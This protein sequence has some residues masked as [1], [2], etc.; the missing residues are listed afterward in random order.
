M[1]KNKPLKY[2]ILLSTAAI[3]LAACTPQ[4]N[5]FSPVPPP[6]EVPPLPQ[7]NTLEV[8]PEEPAEPEYDAFLPISA[9]PPVPD[10]ELEIEKSL[11]VEEAPEDTSEKTLEEEVAATLAEET[12]KPEESFKP[13]PLPTNKLVD[14]PAIARGPAPQKAATPTGQAPASPPKMPAKGPQGGEVID[15]STYNKEEED[16]APTVAAWE[17]KPIEEGMVEEERK[18]PIETAIS[19]PFNVVPPE[20]RVPLKP[21]KV[22]DFTQLRARESMQEGGIVVAEAKTVPN[23]KDTPKIGTKADCSGIGLGIAVATS[24]GEKKYLLDQDGKPCETAEVMFNGTNPLQARSPSQ[25]VDIKFINQFETPTKNQ[26]PIAI[27]VPKSTQKTAGEEVPPAPTLADIQWFNDALENAEP[28]PKAPQ[29]A[30]A[31]TIQAW[32]KQKKEQVKEN[33]RVEEGTLAADLKDIQRYAAGEL[34]TEYQQQVEE[35]A[36]RLREVEVQKELQQKRHEQVLSRLETDQQKNSAQTEA[37]REEERRLRQN[38]ENLNLKAAEME[39]LNSR[40]KETYSTREKE[41]MAKIAKLTNDLKRA[42]Q[43]ASKAR[44]EMVMEAAKKIAEAERLAFAARMA[45][46]EQME[47]EAVRL[48][49]E[50]STMMQRA[51]DIEANRAVMVPNLSGE[52]Q[53]SFPPVEP[54]NILAQAEQTEDD[55]AIPPIGTVPVVLHVKDMPLQQVFETVFKNIAPVMGEWRVNWEISGTNKGILEEEWTVT[56]ETTFEDF[57]DYVKTQVKKIHGVE[58]KYNRFDQ[59]RLFVVAD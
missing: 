42:E 51:N 30:L 41:Y 17:M 52:L 54:L 45:K 55:F 25:S 7:F 11:T 19:L 16:L 14:M 9:L 59:N 4:Q 3:A 56:A 26:Q 6:H 29:D 31:G 58:L 36:K 35:M 32:Q 33:I 1:N 24:T 48:K 20:A 23:T 8:P 15:V 18:L 53:E 13:A 38:V 37:W 27:N 5:I 21:E 28:A 22:R 2:T 34:A 47:R 49:L 10:V 12:K 40:L 44:Q 43:Q 39:D 46:K 57:L 50:G